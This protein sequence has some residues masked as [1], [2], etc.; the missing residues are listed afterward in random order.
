VSRL[1]EEWFGAAFARLHPKLQALHRKGGELEGAVEISIATGAAGVLG[2]RL[3]KG[4]GVPVTLGAHR[5]RVHI[6]SDA[7]VLHWDRCFDGDQWFRSNFRPVGRYPEGEW[8]ESI[9]R[10]E[11]RL[12]VEIEHG[13][14]QW[15]ARGLR[16]FNF[17]VPAWLQPQV[18]AGKQIVGDRYR[19]SV[20][21][22]LPALGTVLQYQGDL[23][24]RT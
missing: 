18:I 8:I 7:Q 9:G 5:L 20:G 24:A 1:V 12:G 2:R 13:A 23:S 16:A 3:A 6:H 4:L 21:I 10:I 22:S 19:F 17:D 14:W 11:Q 15:Q